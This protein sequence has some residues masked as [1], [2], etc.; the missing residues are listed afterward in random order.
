[1]DNSKLNNKF[2][3]NDILNIAYR[4]MYVVPIALAV[5]GE[6]ITWIKQL[7]QKEEMAEIAS[8]AAAVGGI[9]AGTFLLFLLAAFLVS[10]V[11]TLTKWTKIVTAAGI[12]IGMVVVL[13]TE[14]WPVRLTV[15]ALLWLIPVLLADIFRTFSSDVGRKNE[16]SV[17]FL[18]P[19][20]IISFLM[21]N[22]IPISAR[23]VDWSGVVNVYERITEASREF[24]SKISWG[25]YSFGDSVMGFDGSGGVFG[26]I[27]SSNKIVME[28]SR[29]YPSAGALYLTGKVYS[30]F[31]GSEWSALEEPSYYSR[32]MDTIETMAAISDTYPYNE[33]ALY[34]SVK[35]D[36]ELKDIETSYVF[37]PSKMIVGAKNSISVKYDRDNIL[38]FS[39]EKY[40]Y[41]YYV[42]YYM[43]NRGGE[44]LVKYH[45][46]ITEETW[47]KM[48]IRF[49][50]SGG[51]P[52][53]Y[54][55][56]LNY[57]EYVREAYC[58]PLDNS[59][60]VTAL[61][62]QITEGAT[63]D[64][65]KLKCIEN[66]LASHE[67]TIKV[68]R[69][70]R[71]IKSSEEYLDYFLMENTSGFC[72]Y[73]ATAFVLMA[74][75]E[76]IPARYVEGY[77]IP[78]TAS[79]ECEVTSNMAHAWAEAYFEGVGWIR[80]EP[81]PG[82]GSV[83][84]WGEPLREP[85]YYEMLEEQETL[86]EKPSEENLEIVEEK[87]EDVP[88]FDSSKRLEEEARRK[89]EAKRRQQ[90]IIF[91]VTA[92]LLGIFLIAI[93]LISIRL[94]VRSVKYR[95]LSEDDKKTENCMRCLL[96]LDSLERKPMQGETLS[97]FELR[98]REEFGLEKL[99]FIDAYEH[100]LYRNGT[101]IKVS[102]LE[103]EYRNIKQLMHGRKRVKANI[104][105][106]MGVVFDRK[107]FL[108]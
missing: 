62:E 17:V 64:Y 88:Q 98:V 25:T 108:D 76:G 100:I 91:I 57:R 72:T 56:L 16:S 80:F 67:Y 85:E 22:F 52:Y 63:T 66:W 1:M 107:V 41:K 58:E 51:D 2:N 21:T 71:K 15:A 89:E 92:T 102:D 26:K 30:D 13:F 46:D 94:I 10:L 74:R 14:M 55:D 33:K 86:D 34:S 32:M 82:F 5:S 6:G 68:D 75:A 84:S 29:E 61:I 4:L 73:Y 60:E 50:P 78:S 105:F 8:S 103:K 7:L 11:I 45:R 9:Y 69:G 65:E 47:K 48:A 38:F 49:R 36:I 39:N 40:G 27:N 42:M 35:V 53:T 23:P 87:R 90:T 54:Q 104:K 18:L 20:L 70:K 37:A 59:E 93:I 79:K 24:F 106:A 3:K 19:F 96:V 99:K 83:A 44:D 95:H 101:V 12:L 77:R 31:D 28:V 43:L 81:T 97:E